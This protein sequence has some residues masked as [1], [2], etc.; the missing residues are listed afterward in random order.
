MSA[1]TID[2]FIDNFLMAVDFQD[3]VEVTAETE[4]RSLPE[5]DSLA[6]L[7]TIVLFDTE[8]N[9]HIVGDDI[10]NATTVGDLYALLG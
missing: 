6:A 8:Y 10:K 1:P 5:W 2:Q 9:K 7:A 3:P 4:L